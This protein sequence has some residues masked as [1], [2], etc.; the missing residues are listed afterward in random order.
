MKTLE[1]TIAIPNKSFTVTSNDINNNNALLSNILYNKMEKFSIDVVLSKSDIA[2][3]NPRL[4]KLQIL[5]NAYLNDT[6]LL[7]SKI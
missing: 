3:P 2:F 6:L 1:N 7:N 5:K 4:Y